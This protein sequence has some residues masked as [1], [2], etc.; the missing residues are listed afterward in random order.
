MLLNG[1]K[2]FENNFKEISLEELQNTDN[3]ETSFWI[4]KLKMKNLL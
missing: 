2:E 1:W 4:Q 3:P